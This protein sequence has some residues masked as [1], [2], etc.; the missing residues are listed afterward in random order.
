MSYPKVKVDEQID[1]SPVL[2]SRSLT[3]PAGFPVRCIGMTSLFGE[4]RMRCCEYA[5]VQANNHTMH[6]GFMAI[7][8]GDRMKKWLP[9]W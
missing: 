3:I 8:F 2:D 5:S 4:T 7:S 9:Q 6:N 1:A